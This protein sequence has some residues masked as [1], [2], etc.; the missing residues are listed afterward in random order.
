MSV[1]GIQTATHLRMR[2]DAGA[3]L[4]Q[5]HAALG[6]QGPWLAARLLQPVPI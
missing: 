3:R 5:V 4:V 1:G 2:M 6:R